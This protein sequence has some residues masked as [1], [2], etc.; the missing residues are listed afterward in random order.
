MGRGGGGGELGENHQRVVKDVVS[1]NDSRGW[2]DSP[3]S[4]SALDHIELTYH[5][6]GLLI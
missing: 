2:L 1:N 6:V 5:D 4:W 3:D